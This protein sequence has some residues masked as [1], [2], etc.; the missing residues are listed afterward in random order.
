LIGRNLVEQDM[1]FD[2]GNSSKDKELIASE[3]SLHSSPEIICYN[4]IEEEG[5]IFLISDCIHGKS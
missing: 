1:D 2:L 5:L 3:S 4:W